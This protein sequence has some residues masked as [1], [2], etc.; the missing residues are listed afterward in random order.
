MI[1]L[2]GPFVGLEQLTIKGRFVL[3]RIETQEAAVMEGVIFGRLA[4][5]VTQ[6]FQLTEKKSREKQR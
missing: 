2:I 6:A 3:D 1:Y 4:H 5:Q